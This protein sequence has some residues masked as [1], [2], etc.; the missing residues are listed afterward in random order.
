MPP[1]AREAEA[2]E[3]AA[4]AGDR[5]ALRPD[6]TLS[7]TAA[8]YALPA[9]R[10]SASYVPLSGRV[11]AP[12]EPPPALPDAIPDPDSRSPAAD[13][14]LAAAATLNP[15]LLANANVLGPILQPPFTA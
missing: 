3:V 9:R 1:A 15:Q 5:S 8:I 10:T 2:V 7:G 11:P 14:L 13:Q 6:D 4:L 12:D